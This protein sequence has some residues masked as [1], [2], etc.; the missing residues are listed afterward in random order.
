MDNISWLPRNGVSFQE[1]MPLTILPGIVILGWYVRFARG[2]GRATGTRIK[3]GLGGVLRDSE[4]TSR[5]MALY[6][7]NKAWND[8]HQAVSS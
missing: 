8:A 7:S 6:F 4:V 3:Q 1:R 2:M 5:R